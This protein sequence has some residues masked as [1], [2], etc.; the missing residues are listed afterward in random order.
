MKTH[1]FYA[2]ILLSLRTFFDRFALPHN[3]VKGYRFNIGN[4]SLQLNYDTK[5]DLPWMMIDYQSSRHVA[6]H[7]HTWLK[8]QYDNTSKYVVLFDK[9]KNLSMLMQEE[10]YEFQV[11][12]TLN[13]ESQLQALQLKH[14]IEKFLVPGRYFQLYSFF[15]FFTIDDRYLHDTM[16]DVNNDKIYNIFMRYD[17]LRDSTVYC[18][19]VKY[20][21]L[22]RLDSAEVSIGSTEQRSFQVSMQLNIIN[23]MPIYTEIPMYERSKPDLVQE[24]E[25]LD[26]FIPL[27]RRYNILSIDCKTI[28]NIHYYSPAIV[29]Q[30]DFNCNVSYAKYNPETESNDYEF[31]GNLTGSIE[32]IKSFGTFKT[33]IDNDDHEVDYEKVIDVSEDSMIIRLIGPV[34]GVIVKVTELPQYGPNYIRGW[35]NGVIE[36]TPTKM[37][38]EGNLIEEANAV[39]LGEHELQINSTSSKLA[40][41]SVSPCPFGNLKYLITDFNAK[42]LRLDIRTTNITEIV[43]FHNLELYT[44]PIEITFDDAGNF[45]QSFEYEIGAELV[46]GCIFGKLHPIQMT[47]HTEYIIDVEP[48]KIV[49][50]KCNFRFKSEVGYGA[51]IVDKINLNIVDEITPVSSAIGSASYFKNDFIELEDRNN[52]LLLQNIILSSD[53][54]DDFFI[55]IEDSNDVKIK[56]VLAEQFDFDKANKS[57]NLYWRFYLNLD[58]SIIDENTVGISLIERVDDDPHNVIYF[59]CTELIF[60]KYFRNGI[61]VDN[62]VF[63][64]LYKLY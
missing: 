39:I 25:Q 30:T 5:F 55:P 28:D 27:D 13:C 54:I 32:K 64:Q 49:A 2:D 6:Y 52:K 38:I 57:A 23:P 56:V 33:I 1:N 37:Q 34:S 35:F 59:H 63:F 20:E 10:L 22:I 62:P 12:A 4:R 11:Q 24:M 44:F 31:S 51:P 41:F 17:P 40:N 53:Q 36:G 7:T 61:D 42:L 18:F 26:V 43:F 60:D 21:P 8:T 3:Q 19:S 16:F 50:L 9:T 48:I 14:D 29:Y 58:R 47:L 45:K 46:K 15:S